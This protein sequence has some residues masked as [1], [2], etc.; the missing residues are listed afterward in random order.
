MTPRGYAHGGIANTRQGYLFGGITRTLKKI[1]PKEIPQTLNKLI[2]NEIKPALPYVAAALP[3]MLGPEFTMLGLP[4]GASRALAASLATAGSQMAQKDYDKLGLNPLTIGLS[5]LTGYLS[6]PGIGS[7]LGAAKT[8]GNVNGVPVTPENLNQIVSANTAPTLDI[9]KANSVLESTP[10]YSGTDLLQKAQNLGLSAGKL[11]ADYLGKGTTAF[12]NLIGGGDINMSDVT[13]L[14]KAASPGITAASSEQAYNAAKLAQ[15][16]YDKQQ[17]EMAATFGAQGVA[18]QSA[19]RAAVIHALTIS[20]F[21]QTGI[22]SALK[23]LGLADGGVSTMPKFIPMDPE[24]VGLRL[25]GKNIDNLSYIEKQAVR[26][27][28][29]D[30]KNK[31]ADGGLMSLKGHEMDFRDGGGFVPIGKK[32]RADDVPARLSK[33]EFVFTAKAVR[34]AGHGDIKAGAKRMYQLMKHLEAK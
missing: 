18:D 34:N 1:I 3:F 17:K 22:D 32:E 15:M 19:R 24:S 6:T 23:R 9:T 11:G 14:G 12:E 13:A 29:D 25:F 16:E 2:P 5:G 30:N 33:N 8:L 4:A 31:K 27:Y 20:G 28:I 10:G 21:D 7:E 26:D